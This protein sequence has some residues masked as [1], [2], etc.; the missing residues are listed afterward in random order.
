MTT[1]VKWCWWWW[2]GKEQLQDQVLIRYSVNFEEEGKCLSWSV[3]NQQELFRNVVVSVFFLFFT[4]FPD[5]RKSNSL[6]QGCERSLLMS[7]V[8][9]RQVA[10][11]KVLDRRL[12][13]PSDPRGE[14]E[15]LQGSLWSAAA[16]C[17]VEMKKAFRMYI[18]YEKGWVWERKD[19]AMST[20]KR[21]GK[22]KPG[23]LFWNCGILKKVS[24]SLPQERTELQ[25]CG[26]MRQ[27]CGKYCPWIG[28][29][30]TA[31]NAVPHPA[32]VAQLKHRVV[33]LPCNGACV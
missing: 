14:G 24:A 6:C 20:E 15:P 12:G 16:R 21:C 22:N 7:R 17:K 11:I 2:S 28:E 3:T 13:D 9:R 33:A 5:S 4:F 31:E 25:L 30:G 10:E 18:Q 27:L 32:S 8:L 29:E 26:R 19:G 23:G 1:K